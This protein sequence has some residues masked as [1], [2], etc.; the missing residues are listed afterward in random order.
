MLSRA[1]SPSLS[2]RT[3]RSIVFSPT[4]HARIR[5]IRKSGHIKYLVGSMTVVLFQRRIAPGG[6]TRPSR[7]RLG[8]RPRVFDLSDYFC[9]MYLARASFP[10]SYKLIS[11]AGLTNRPA[12]HSRESLNRDSQRVISSSHQR[13]F[14]KSSLPF[15][16]TSP[17]WGTLQ[18]EHY[19]IIALIRRLDSDFDTR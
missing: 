1:R 6:P 8:H 17:Y 16:K 10:P 19:S 11:H 14:A 5:F 3:I 7:A 12:S 4:H 15:I 9:L 2:F 18:P 13:R